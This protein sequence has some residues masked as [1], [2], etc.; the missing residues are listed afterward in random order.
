ML[1]TVIAKFKFNFQQDLI[2]K[3]Q[4][5]LLISILFT[6]LI[7]RFG[8]DKSL[9]SV[10]LTKQTLLFC[11]LKRNYFLSLSVRKNSF[12]DTPSNYFP[13]KHYLIKVG[14]YP[15]T[16]LILQQTLPYSTKAIYERVTR[17]LR[18]YFAFSKANFIHG[19]ESW[20]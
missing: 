19:H 17:L 11:T 10:S 9:K 8:G 20:H 16:F 13:C 2:N 3:R 6:I 1:S 7:M 5:F 18:L 14:G 4:L 15:S 12:N